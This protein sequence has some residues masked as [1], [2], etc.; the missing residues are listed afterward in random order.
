MMRINCPYCGSRTED[1]FHCGGQSHIVRPED[2][3]S[4]SDEAWSAYLYEREN[5]KGVH[6]E[7]WCHRYGCGQWFNV[8]RD[9]VSHEIHTV[10]A[11][12]E[13][14]PVVLEPES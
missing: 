12:T 14:K 2:P 1:E 13:P 10:Y 4:V 8:A 6:Y 7:R 9:L 11:M 5:P 3:A